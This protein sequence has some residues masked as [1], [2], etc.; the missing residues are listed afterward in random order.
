MHL[1]YAWF[2]L[3]QFSATIFPYIIRFILLTNLRAI[4][5]LLLLNISSSLDIKKRNRISKRGDPYRIPVGIS[6]NS[7]LYPLIIIF[8][9]RP[10]R[11]V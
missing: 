5:S 4:I 1:L 11:K 2:S 8:I 7:L 6:I 9:V 10:I 3:V